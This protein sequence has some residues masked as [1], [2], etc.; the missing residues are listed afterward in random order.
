[1]AHILWELLANLMQ[2]K[3]LKKKDKL[4]DASH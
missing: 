1:M 3:K 2:F 4:N